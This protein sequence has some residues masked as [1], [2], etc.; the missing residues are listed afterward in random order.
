MNVQEKI[1]L[2]DVS[3]RLHVGQTINM[4]L[5]SKIDRSGV[6]II[7]VGANSGMLIDMLKLSGV[8]I[9]SAVL[10]EPQPDLCLYMRE[11]YKN[12]PEIVVENIALGNSGKGYWLDDS[13]FQHQMND[14]FNNAHL[15]LGLSGIN[16]SK[17]SPTKCFAFDDLYPKYNLNKIDII[18]IDTE[19][20]DLIVLS[21]FIKTV[22][23]LSVKP[24]IV[25]ENNWKIKHEEK[26]AQEMVDRF[27]SSCGYNKINITEKLTDFRLFPL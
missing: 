9:A 12:N 8:V 17:E 19:G 11:K 23:N 7:D 20:H 6:V 25:F 5:N 27:C 15:N 13:S 22:S 4:I 10:F 26:E 16:Y 21:G 24:F 18:K 14:G 3:G 1:K 2:W